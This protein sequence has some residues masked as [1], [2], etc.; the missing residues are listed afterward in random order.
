MAVPLHDNL[1]EIYRDNLEE[2]GRE[3]QDDP[4]VG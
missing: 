4:G 1:G 3:Y 2:V